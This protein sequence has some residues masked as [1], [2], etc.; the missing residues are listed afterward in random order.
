MRALI[1]GFVLAGGVAAAEPDLDHARSLYQQAS[2]EMKNGRYADAATDFGAVYDITKDP[3]LFYKIATA[4]QK[5]G[6]CDVA[7]VYYQRYLKEAHP[8]LDFVKLAEAR[9]KEC[10]GDQAA[11]PPTPPVS[12]SP[13]PAPAPAPS[14][15]PP[16]PPAPA[17]APAIHTSSSRNT[18]WILVGSSLALITLG[19]VLAYSASSSEQDLKDLYI[20]NVGKP[21]AYDAK[22]AQMYQDL[23]D[24]GHTYEHLSWAAFGAAGACALGA[25]ILWLREPDVTVAPIATKHE[26]GVAATLRF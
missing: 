11:P 7:V 26:T 24:T 6:H 18:E 15:S 19:G 8:S 13:P 14:P 21:P 12:P 4:Q 25:A 5:A 1:V 17:P 16:P 2:D 3:V 9:I 23:I 10:G 20:S 22:T